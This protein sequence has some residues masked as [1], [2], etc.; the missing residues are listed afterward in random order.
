MNIFQQVFASVNPR[1]AEI[2]KERDPSSCNR[3]S[4]YAQKPVTR[5]LGKKLPG[6]GEV[7]APKKTVPDVPLPSAES[8]V[9]KK[10]PPVKNQM[11]DVKKM[12][13]QA[14]AKQAPSFPLS[15]SKRKPSIAKAVK[16]NMKKRVE[17]S[18]QEEEEYDEAEND[19]LEE[20]C[21]E[22]ERQIADLTNRLDSAK[23]ELAS[24]QAKNSAL[25]RENTQL[26]CQVQKLEDNAK[27][28]NKAMIAMRKS[29]E[30]KMLETEVTWEYRVTDML[31]QIQTMKVTE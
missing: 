20:K 16:M 14:I 23:E 24:A 8:I 9:M 12:T 29:F 1:S 17:P 3:V 21:A 13:K 7:A 27:E 11:V 30:E 26:E 15:P 4:S 31:A 6:N 10:Q 25:S 5:A 18:P 28:A 2:L 22:L 19:V